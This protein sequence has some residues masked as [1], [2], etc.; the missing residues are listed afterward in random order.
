MVK[1]KINSEQSFS[2][3]TTKTHFLESSFAKKAVIEPEIPSI[4]FTP[5]SSFSTKERRFLSV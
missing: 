2:E 5:N 1:S 3:G 4:S